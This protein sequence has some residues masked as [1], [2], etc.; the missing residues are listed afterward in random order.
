MLDLLLSL[1][2]HRDMARISGPLFVLPEVGRGAVPTHCILPE[3]L[4]P[5]RKIR[6]REI[7]SRYDT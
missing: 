1:D 7:S 2:L 6:A 5:D 3:N 4:V